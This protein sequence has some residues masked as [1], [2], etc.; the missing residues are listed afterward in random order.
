MGTLYVHLTRAH[1]VEKLPVNAAAVSP[2]NLSQNS[3]VN[4]VRNYYNWLFSHKKPFH[5]AN[6]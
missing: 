6:I 2:R 4:Q 3:N 5:L 1:F